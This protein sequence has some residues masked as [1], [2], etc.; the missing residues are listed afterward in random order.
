LMKKEGIIKTSKREGGTH[1]GGQV[2]KKRERKRVPKRG[3]G[4]EGRGGVSNVRQLEEKKCILKM[5]RKR[6][7]KKT[8]AKRKPVCTTA[9]GNESNK[10]ELEMKKRGTK[11]KGPS[12][13]NVSGSQGGGTGNRIDQMNVEETLN[14]LNVE[15]NEIHDG[16]SFTTNTGG[17]PN[18]GRKKNVR[19]PTKN[20]EEGPQPCQRKGEKNNKKCPMA[21]NGTQNGRI[22]TR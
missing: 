7:R 20:G 15:K 11:E 2:L 1:K 21:K 5:K 22:T 18:G 17:G 9:A 3:G 4:V 8:I 16:E 19:E 13:R 10:E 12:F 14:G 6:E